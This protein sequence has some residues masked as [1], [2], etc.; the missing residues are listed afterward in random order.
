[1]KTRRSFSPI[2]S[3]A[4]RHPQN[5]YLALHR[6]PNGGGMQKIPLGGAEALLLPG[7]GKAAPGSATRSQEFRRASPNRKPTFPRSPSNP[8]CDVHGHCRRARVAFTNEGPTR[9]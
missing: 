6:R 4:R 7:E 1:R 3:S 2:E 8:V 9:R 5:R